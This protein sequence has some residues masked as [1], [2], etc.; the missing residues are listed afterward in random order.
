MKT[1]LNHLQCKIFENW[2]GFDFRSQQENDVQGVTNMSTF[3][4][5]KVDRWNLI[6]ETFWLSS[7]FKPLYCYKKS[8]AI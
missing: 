5:T 3:Y 7:E 4:E 8:H 6:E 1:E 2:V